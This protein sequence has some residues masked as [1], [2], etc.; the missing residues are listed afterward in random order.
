MGMFMRSPMGTRSMILSERPNDDDSQDGFTKWPFMT[1]HTWAEYPRGEWTLVLHG[2]K[3]APYTSLP[4]SDP[5]SKLAVVKKAHE[6]RKKEL[7]FILSLK[8]TSTFNQHQRSRIHQ[9]Q[10]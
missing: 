7:Y 4:V 5:H 2:T 6:K 1:T 3:E 10:Y 8:I 9:H